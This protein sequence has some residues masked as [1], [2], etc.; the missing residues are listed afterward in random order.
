MKI[1]TKCKQSKEFSNFHKDSKTNDGLKCWCIACM[2]QS[3]IKFD[4]EHPENYRNKHLKQ[5]YGISI[6][7]YNE[8]LKLQNF[9]CAICLKHM[10]E[11]KKGMVVDHSH[12]T[13]KVRA[14]LCCRCNHYLVGVEDSI[15]K[16]RAEE[17][18]RKHEVIA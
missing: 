13:G 16:Q 5:T 8:L 6:G 17:Y 1:C 2:R 3:R 4:F 9:R 15:F 14:I 18:L 12:V 11:S 7:Q 10:T